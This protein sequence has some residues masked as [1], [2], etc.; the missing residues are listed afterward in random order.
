LEDFEGAIYRISVD[1]NQYKVPGGFY[2]FMCSF[3]GIMVAHGELPDDAFGQPLSEIFVALELGT[4][5]EG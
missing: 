3:D 4:K 1:E 2:L 5:E